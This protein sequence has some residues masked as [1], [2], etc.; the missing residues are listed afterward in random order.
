MEETI[1]VKKRNGTDVIYNHKKIKN[2]IYKAAIATVFD[3]ENALKI[4][5][6]TTEIVNNTIHNIAGLSLF[7]HVEEVQDIVEK[8]L[9]KRYP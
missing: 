3:K 8:V 2:A 7:I 5:N 9:M 1:I 4:A 6:E